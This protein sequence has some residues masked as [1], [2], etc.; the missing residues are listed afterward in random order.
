MTM[1]KFILLSLT[2][3]VISFSCK[4]TSGLLPDAD[5]DYNGKYHCWPYDVTVYSI[6][7]IKIDSL[8]YAYPLQ[9]YF[10]SN[11]KYKTST[12]T[13]Y[14]DFDSTIWTG[15][16]KVLEQCDDNHQLYKRIINGEDVYYA[17][18]YHYLKNKQG[19]EKKRYETILFLDVKENEL[20]LFR[21]INK[22][23]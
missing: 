23:Y 8:F 6:D 13:K 22:V 1:I 16:N 12:W 15:M 11:T 5:I 4:R 19:E 17:G 7:N 3:L 21:D 2:L 9:N 10:G 14:A 18:S 20:H